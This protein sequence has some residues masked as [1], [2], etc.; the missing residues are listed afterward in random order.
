M[1]S[2]DI[3][4]DIGPIDAIILDPDNDRGL[5]RSPPVRGCTVETAA[6]TSTAI[7]AT[8]IWEDFYMRKTLLIIMAMAVLTFGVCP[9]AQADEDY[10]LKLGHTGAPNHHYQKICT[11]FADEVAKKDR[12]PRQDSG[13]PC[14]PARKTAGSRGRLHAGNPGHGSDFGHRALQLGAGHGHSEPALPVQ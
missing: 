5:Q 3:Y 8:T 11:M 10:V 12:R 9:L 14:R 1:M 6:K 2:A 7:V 13:L 4:I